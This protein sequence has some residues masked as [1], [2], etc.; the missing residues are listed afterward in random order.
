MMM[1]F[2]DFWM[3]R[4]IFPLLKLGMPI[5]HLA[6]SIGVIPSLLLIVLFWYGLWYTGRRNDIPLWLLMPFALIGGADAGLIGLTLE[7]LGFD[8]LFNRDWLSDG[9]YAFVWLST[10]PSGMILGA[11]TGLVLALQR[12]R[13]TVGCIS[14]LF[15]L[16]TA[17]PV[18]YLYFATQEERT[19]L[20]LVYLP[21]PL[22][23]IVL[24]VYYLVKPFRR[25]VA[26]SL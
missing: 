26:E 1:L 20:A 25:S 6:L 16:I 22:L 9:Q 4:V 21:W 2:D 17:L 18:A 10:V 19:A 3:F 11:V 24:G 15:G 8:W 13:K 5:L 23:L 12:F 14:L 7:R